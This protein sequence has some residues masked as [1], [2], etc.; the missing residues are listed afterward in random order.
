MEIH[1]VTSVP[2]GASYLVSLAT[3]YTIET[4]NLVVLSGLVS[5]FGVISNLVN[6][7][8]FWRH[9]FRESINVGLTA[10]AVSDL[11][12]VIS[13]AILSVC[14]NPLIPYSEMGVNSR[15]VQYLVGAHPRFCFA[16]ITG[17]I[18]V[19]I[20]LERCLCVAVPLHV[21]RILTPRRTFAVVVLIFTL[22]FLIET[23]IYMAHKLDWKFSYALNRSE[24]SLVSMSNAA[25][26]ENLSFG[27]SVCVQFSSFGLLLILT[28][29]LV[30]LLKKR[31]EWRLQ[32]VSAG[33]SDKN[34]VS[35]RE[36]GAIRLTL[37]VSTI[38]IC[39]LFPSTLLIITSFLEPEFNF[40]RR[41]QNMYFSVW[42]I[43]SLGEVSNSSVNIF[44]Y[45]KMN[46]RYRET[47]RGVFCTKSSSKEGNKTPVNVS[48]TEKL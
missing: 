1:N 36:R 4:I 10:L 45:Y 28:S 24:I 43:V 42:T 13:G 34:N 46:S 48:H 11:G 2:H 6:L 8:I 3:L 22:I 21:K 40:G 38:L 17:L 14:F 41:Y 5:I 27:L 15:D 31:S 9:G 16:R 7:S 12:T 47:F 30:L 23:P 32:T 35:R 20:T 26:L 25:E 44:V 29:T 37:M 33:P 19:Y 18:T 39:F